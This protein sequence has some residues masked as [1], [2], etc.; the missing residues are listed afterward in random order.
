M[1]L[2]L[3]THIWLWS[4][5][6]QHKL[7]SKT[8]A[9]LRRSDGAIWIS[10][11][12]V[13]EALLLVEKGRYQIPGDAPKA[14]LKGLAESGIQELVFDHRVAIESRRILMDH[15]DP[16]DR[17]LAATANI[18][19]LTLVTADETLLRSGACQVFPA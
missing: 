9:L 1:K 7:N 17:M 10:A 6:E 4:I 11:L 16:T 12:S 2:L 13:W 14:L 18:Y 8:A 15:K 19:H 5:F 3:D